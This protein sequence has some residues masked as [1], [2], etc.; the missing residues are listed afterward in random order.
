MTR[1][2]LASFLLVLIAMIAFVE[3]PLGIELARHERE[4]FT[5]TTT[6]S[7]RSLAAAAE[8]RLGDADEQSS[9]SGL[10]LDVDGGDTVVVA[11]RRGTVIAQFG[12]PLPAGGS[13]S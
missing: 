9:T 11:N 1:R 4:D 7:A 12:S 10:H 3:I 8:E 6:A 13:E 2:V 5:L